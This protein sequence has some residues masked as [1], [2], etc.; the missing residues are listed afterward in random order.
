MFSIKLPISL[1]LPFRLL[2]EASLAHSA[3]IALMS[4]YPATSK[5][6]LNSA[7]F[8]DP[9]WATAFPSLVKMLRASIVFLTFFCCQVSDD[10]TMVRSTSLISSTFCFKHLF[11]SLFLME[12]FTKLLKIS[13]A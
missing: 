3:S 2:I 4:L 1:I 13:I 6:F 12:L 11:S 10:L 9:H 8:E 5:F 7:S